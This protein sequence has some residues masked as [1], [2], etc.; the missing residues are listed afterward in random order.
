MSLENKK[1]EQEFCPKH[2][3]MGRAI[4]KHKYDEETEENCKRIREKIDRGK[5]GDE[6][7]S[8]GKT[9]NW[10]TSNGLRT[11]H[12]GHSDAREI[13]HLLQ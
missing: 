8:E 3:R 13:L 4:I 7:S 2:L 6:I 12:N 5:N 11:M 9:N 1:L 10:N